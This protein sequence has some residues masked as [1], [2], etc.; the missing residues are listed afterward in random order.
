MW[1][2]D[3]YLIYSNFHPFSKKKKKKTSTPQTKVVRLDKNLNLEGKSSCKEGLQCPL[4]KSGT[5]NKY[6]KQE[7]SPLK[8]KKPVKLVMHVKVHLAEGVLKRSQRVFLVLLRQIKATTRL[9][10]LRLGQM[11]ERAVARDHKQSYL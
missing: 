5:T 1:Y 6:L 11:A 10:K 7:R 8:R 3:L 9:L 2:K 4:T